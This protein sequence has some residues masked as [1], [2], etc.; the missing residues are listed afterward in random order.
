[1]VY[2]NVQISGNERFFKLTQSNK[3][4]IKISFQGIKPNRSELFTWKLKH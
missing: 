3:N 4:Q 2:K 1:M